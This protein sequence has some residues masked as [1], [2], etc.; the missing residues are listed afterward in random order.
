MF[1]YLTM[2]PIDGVAYGL[3]NL[4]EL[5]ISCRS[6]VLTLCEQYYYF[7]IVF[8]V[9]PIRHTFDSIYLRPDLKCISFFQ[10]LYR[11]EDL[12]VTSIVTGIYLALLY[13][14]LQHLVIT[15]RTLSII[16]H[17]SSTLQ[18]LLVVVRTSIYNNTACILPIVLVVS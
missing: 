11:R 4:V 10:L 13:V 17:L 15:I 9:Q 12:S 1:T 18:R 6:P 5:I 8:H 14:R 3:S 2:R 7:S 16:V